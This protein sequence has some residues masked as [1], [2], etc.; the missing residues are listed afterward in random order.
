MYPENLDYSIDS[1]TWTETETVTYYSKTTEAI[2]SAGAGFSLPRTVWTTIDRD[3]IK[4]DSELSKFQF[5]VQIAG[6]FFP[7]ANVPKAND[8]MLR[9]NG[10]RWIIGKI[11]GPDVLDYDVYVEQDFSYNQSVNA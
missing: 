1:D 7:S 8:L 11:E 5:R 10:T 9:T 4:G 6:K 2:L 3:E